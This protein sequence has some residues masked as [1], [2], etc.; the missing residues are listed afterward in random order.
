MGSVMIE[1]NVVRAAGAAYCMDE[2]EIVRNIEDAGFVAKRRNMHYD[3]LGDPIFRERDVPRMHA[4][5]TARKDG[6]DASMPAELRL[7][8]AR[9]R[10]GKQ[11]RLQ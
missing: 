8:P 5:A 7:Y 10:S 6:D 4:L 3:I 2:A 9:S 11:D 1:E